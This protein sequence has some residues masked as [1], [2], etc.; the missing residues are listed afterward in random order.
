MNIAT[1]LKEAFIIFTYCLKYFS[2]YYM[3]ISLLYAVI[4]TYVNEKGK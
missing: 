2:I 1:H 3:L 4:H